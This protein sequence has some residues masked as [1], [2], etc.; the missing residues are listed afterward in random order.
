MLWGVW[1]ALYVVCCT[2]VF[3]SNWGHAICYLR[4]LTG[5]PCTDYEGYRE[6]V[7]GSLPQLEWLDGKEVTRSERILATQRLPELRKRIAEQQEE[8]MRERVRTNGC[9]LWDFKWP[10]PP[11]FLLSAMIFL[12][13]RLVIVHNR[14][15]IS[16]LLCTYLNY[17]CQCVLHFLWKVVSSTYQAIFISCSISNGRK[18]KK[19]RQR[20]EVKPTRSQASTRGG[21]LIQ[22][23]TLP[24]QFSVC[25]I[26]TVAYRDAYF[27]SYLSGSSAGSH[28]KQAD[29]TND[30]DE[31]RYT[32]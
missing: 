7:V 28:H 25:M 11:I 30:A 4:Y 27:C 3:N 6:F 19:S 1:H 32:L 17:S 29:S 13:K 18:R 15:I 2:W 24:S 31:E 20:K 23:P 9:M 5:N 12:A 8:Y 14:K 22:T 10:A 16:M 26:R 21:T